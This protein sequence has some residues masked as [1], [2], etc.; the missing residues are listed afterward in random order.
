MLWMKTSKKT[1]RMR[2][3]QL[4]I[5]LDGVVY[6]FVDAL[7]E[8]LVQQ[9][10]FPRY[11][12]GESTSWN[13]FKDNW[14]MDTQTFLSLF[15]DGVQSGHIFVTGE[16]EPGSIEALT[17]LREAG[18]SIHICTYRTIG[19]RAIPSTVAWLDIHGVPY[20]T[21]TFA[22]D[23]TIIKADA[24]VEDKVENFEALEGVGTRSII[25]DQKW[26]AHLDTEWRARNWKQVQR[27][28]EYI[29]ERRQ[30]EVMA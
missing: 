30:D 24:F 10:G 20:D 2:A 12:L 14:G 29:A 21:I 7:R 23:K 5:D 19:P 4:G 28:V 3:L 27:M 22:E 17:T 18:H 13:F 1:S 16:P 6:N 8:Y 26:N 11:E 25:F 15:R 9:R